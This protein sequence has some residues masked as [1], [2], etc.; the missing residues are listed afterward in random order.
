VGIPELAI[1]VTG[2]VDVWDPTTTAILD[3]FAVVV[4]G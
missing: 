2:C 4:G 1:V 3:D